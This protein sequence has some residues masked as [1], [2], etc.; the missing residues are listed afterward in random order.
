MKDTTF[1]QLIELTHDGG[2]FVPV[3]ENAFT[4]ADNSWQGEPIWLLEAS[5]RD[6]MRHK[7][8]MSLLASVWG[9]MPA[10][11]KKRCPEKYFYKW[12]KH[13]KKNYSLV[14]SFK[15]QEKKD[16]HI[17]YL[18][19]NKKRFRLTYKAIEEIA[20]NTAKSDMIEYE[21]ISFGKMT[22]KRF[23]EYIKE[24]LP[25]LYENV[26]GACYKDEAKDNIIAEIEKNYK[27]FLSRL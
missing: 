18:K 16:R 20:D 15:D 4:L 27:K 11:F 13:L 14:F 9:F 3:N 26:I 22:E 5:A 1:T 6:L 24:Q 21:S 19:E 25:F 17:E 8:Y 10:E 7:C 12:L 2:V 23:H